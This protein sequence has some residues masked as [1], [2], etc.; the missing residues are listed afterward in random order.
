M[1]VLLSKVK[2]NMHTILPR[3]MAYNKP[4]VHPYTEL[5]LHLLMYLRRPHTNLHMILMLLPPRPQVIYPKRL[6]MK[7]YLDLGHPPIVP[8]AL[9]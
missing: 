9:Q 5:N 8:T 3:L 1:Q 4:Q 6:L 2:V 7:L